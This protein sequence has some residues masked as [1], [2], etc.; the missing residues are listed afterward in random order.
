MTRNADTRGPGREQVAGTR[1]P[2]GVT[3]IG[4]AITPA[5]PVSRRTLP[6]VNEA[7]S[8]GRS[9]VTSSPVPGVQDQVVRGRGL[10]G[11]GTSRSTRGPGMMSGR[12]RLSYGV[13][14]RDPVERPRVG[15]GVEGRLARRPVG[16]LV[17]LV[18][19]PWTNPDGM[20]GVISSDQVKMLPSS[21]PGE[22]LDPEGPLV[23]AIC[24]PRNAKS[25]S[26]GRN[27]PVNGANPFAIG[28][29]AASS[30]TVPMKS[31]PAAALPVEQDDAWSRPGRSG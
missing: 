21:A 18:A 14:E 22:V 26:S 4:P 28:W 11:D 1:R 8:I 27:V 15:E 10:A 6:G 29:A 31:V 7:A 5:G 20:P 3:V 23:P 16:V 24:R 30:K 13:G 19:E 2:T 9:K 17:H 25:G 12:V